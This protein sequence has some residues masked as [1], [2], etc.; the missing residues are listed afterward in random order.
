MNIGLVGLRSKSKRIPHKNIK[1]FAGKPLCYWIL[2]HANESKL[3]KT[4]VLVDCIEYE[5]IVK[6]FNFKN[7]EILQEKTIT[8]DGNVN[9]PMQFVLDYPEIKFKNLIMLQAPCPFFKEIDK[10][11]DYFLLSGKDSQ[12]CI[13]EEKR[14]FWHDY[15]YPK[16]YNVFQ[17][18]KTQK[19]KS[20]Y[21]EVGACYITS[22]KNLIKQR[23]FLGGNIGLLLLPSYHYYEL[24]NIL[25]WVIMESINQELGILNDV[26][27][28]H[29]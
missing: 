19:I 9:L 7:I 21:V 8:P 23:N 10:A 5:E 13:V 22:K 12:L 6:S 14:F 28:K 18:P 15:G 25:D 2:K 24:E 11:L 27:S 4:Y 1:K 3:D 20:E 16:N 17:R 26:S 29:R